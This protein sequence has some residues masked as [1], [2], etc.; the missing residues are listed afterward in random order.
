MADD[1]SEKKPKTATE[2][3]VVDPS[4][5]GARRPDPLWLYFLS[6]ASAADM[7]GENQRLRSENEQL[8]G[9]TWQLNHEVLPVVVIHA[10]V[11]VDLSRVDTS[12]V[13]HIASFLGESL[14]LLNLALTCKSFGWRQPASSLN[15]SLVEGV[16]CRAVCSR[17]TDAEMGS[18][19]AYTS[20]TTT[21]MPGL[22]ADRY[23]DSGDFGFVDRYFNHCYYRDF[24]AQR[25]DDWGGS[26]IHACE[27][28]PADTV[29][30][31]T[32]WGEEEGSIRGERICPHTSIEEM[33]PIS[34]VLNLD[35]GTMAVHDCAYAVHDKVVLKGG[36][37]GPYCWYV[38]LTQF[39]NIAIKRGTSQT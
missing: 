10:T 22:D 35:E 31:W 5:R 11:V 38:K 13:A 26:N 32:D 33:G 4:E 21:P 39:E 34:I 7:R 14:E 18:L 1:G 8:H 28:D 16:A 2:D 37:S 30:N 6:C 3:G 27:Y 24:L 29:L 36:L 12:I 20:G 15:L 23:L 17:A 9:R 25:S 19:P